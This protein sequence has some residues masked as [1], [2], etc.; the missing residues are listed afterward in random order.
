MKKNCSISEMAYKTIKFRNF[1]VLKKKLKDS[2]SENKIKIKSF[3]ELSEKDIPVFLQIVLEK[4]GNE[5]EFQSNIYKHVMEINLIPI[6]CQDNTGELL[7]DILEKM[8]RD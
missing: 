4:N 1:E 2:F 6:H 7:D 8:P 5:Y 3:P